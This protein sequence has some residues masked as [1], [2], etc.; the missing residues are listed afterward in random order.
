MDINSLREREIRDTLSVSD[1]NKYIGDIIRN[2]KNL[3]VVSVRGEISNFVRHYSGHIYYPFY[4]G[5]HQYIGPIEVAF[6][7]LFDCIELEM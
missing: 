4:Y 7:S 1:L 3:S 6:C 2:N 5:A